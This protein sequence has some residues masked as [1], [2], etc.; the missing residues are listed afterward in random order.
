LYIILNTVLYV[1]YS[2]IFDMHMFC[3]CICYKVAYN[4]IIY[5]SNY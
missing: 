3:S 1:T 4:C 2:C 5:F